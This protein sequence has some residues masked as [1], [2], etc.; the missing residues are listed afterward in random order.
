MNEWMSMNM[1]YMRDDLCVLLTL[2]AFDL[3]G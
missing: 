2:D 1:S 3:A